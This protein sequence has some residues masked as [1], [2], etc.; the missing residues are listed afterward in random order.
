MKWHRLWLR[1]AGWKGRNTLADKRSLT[2]TKAGLSLAVFVLVPM[3]GCRGSASEQD[4]HRIDENIHRLVEF[5]KRQLATV[6]LERFVAVP[7]SPPG[8]PWEEPRSDVN[9]RVS[10][11]P[12]ADGRFHEQYEVIVDP[13][14]IKGSTLATYKIGDGGVLLAQGES[15]ERMPG[16]CEIIVTSKVGKTGRTGR[17][18]KRLEIV[19]RQLTERPV[20]S[21]QIQ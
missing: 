20:V 1:N 17:F 19:D 8:R 13:M 16:W 5:E 18:R 9:V 15:S 7:P 11:L 2:S 14:G 6:D 3:L 21:E 4:R 10:L 12:A